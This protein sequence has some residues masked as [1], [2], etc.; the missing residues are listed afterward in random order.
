MDVST[1]EIFDMSRQKPVTILGL[2]KTGWIREGRDKDRDKNRH[3]AAHA[4]KGK[5]NRNK[6][7]HGD[8]DLAFGS[9]LAQ[10]TLHLPFVMMMGTLDC[11][12]FYFGLLHDSYWGCGFSASAP[13]SGTAIPVKRHMM[14]PLAQE[15]SV[16][17]SGRERQRSDAC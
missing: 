12:Y 11:D 2:E 7:M 13:L 9:C 6:G 17:L 4:A 5:W 8:G 3:G 14:D 15:T 1:V 16:P 10:M